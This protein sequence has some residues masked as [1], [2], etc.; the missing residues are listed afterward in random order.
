MRIDNRQKIHSVADEN[1][2]IRQADGVA[3]L[4][5][6]VGFNSTALELYNAFLHRD[7]S[8]DDVAEWLVA[9]YEVSPDVARADAGAWLQQMRDEKLLLD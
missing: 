8:V 3:D 1:L 5:H 2:I 6:V 9:H 4:T 7:F